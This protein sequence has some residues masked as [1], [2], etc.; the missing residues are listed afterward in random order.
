MIFGVFQAIR[1][2]HLLFAAVSAWEATGTSQAFRNGHPACASRRRASEIR[3]IQSCLPVQVVK[4]VHRRNDRVVPHPGRAVRVHL[5]CRCHGT[6]DR[7]RDRVAAASLTRHAGWLVD[8]CRVRAAGSATCLRR[9][10]RNGATLVT[11]A[12]VMAVTEVEDCVDTMDG[13]ALQPAARA[14]AA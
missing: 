7:G 8:P 13:P 11:G 12:R 2:L 14:V 3:E 4:A 1:S 10:P 6:H 5:L 9:R